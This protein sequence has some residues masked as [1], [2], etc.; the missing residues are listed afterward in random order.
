M[1]TARF[2]DLPV[3]V[4]RARD[5]IA[6]ALSALD[7]DVRN[8]AVLIT[9]ELATNAIRHAHSPFKV[10]V[11][12]SGEGVKVSVTDSSGVVPVPRN[13]SP[14]DAHGRGLMILRALADRWGIDTEPGITTVWFAL[15]LD[16]NPARNAARPR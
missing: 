6:D 16:Q 2:P 11:A 10:T 3:S 9:S 1:S 4:R 14:T 13:P 15:T 8:R 12:L 7:G 5:F